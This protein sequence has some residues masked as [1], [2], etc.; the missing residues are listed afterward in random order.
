MIRLAEEAVSRG[1]PATLLTGAYWKETAESRGIHF[2][3]TPPHGERSEHA[4]FMRR[5]SGIRNKRRLLEAMFAQVDSWQE[6]IL[7]LLDTALK[8]A[9]ALVCSYLFPFYHRLADARGLPTVSAHFCPNTSYSPEYP[10]TDLP[11][12]PK[13]F[14]RPARILWNRSLTSLAD[15]YLV[16]RL[17][18]RL[19][20]SGQHLSSWLRSPTRYNLILAPGSL[21]CR[22]ANDLPPST[23][24]T[25]F[26][27]AGFSAKEDSQNEIHFDG[28]PLL[29]FGSVTTSEMESEFAAL[30]ERWPQNRRLTIQEGWFRPPAPPAESG[31]RVIGSAPHKEVFPKASVLV[32][33][34]GAGT[35]TSG[36]MAGKPQIVIPHF[37]D[38]DFWGKTVERMGCGRQM[39]RRGWGRKLSRVL[40]GVE[41][42]SSMAGRAREIA[43]EQTKEDGASNGLDAIERWLEAES[44][45]NRTHAIG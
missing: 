3:A 24:F 31:I 32:H 27:P 13:F 39:S 28:G 35:T 2:I 40:E 5:F 18:K 44:A 38:Q 17:N 11:G 19:S 9:D 30:Y 41:K 12:L 42:N 14:P 33:H 7:P 16:H 25:G 22:S 10:P 15:R 23:V 43:R 29:T 8:S 21:F 4:D 6:E 45:G 37:A 26:L 20:R 1:H 34:G 36:L